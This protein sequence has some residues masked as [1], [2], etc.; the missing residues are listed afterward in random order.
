MSIANTIS[1]IQRLNRTIS[2]VKLAP[3]KYPG[4][5]NSADLPLVL[6]WP[7]RA[8][9]VPLTSRAE[10]VKMQR[11]Y[12]VRV[13][14]EAAGQDD[15]TAPTNRGVALLNNFLDT[16]FRNKILEAGYAEIVNI[17]DTCLISGGTSV[18]E[19]MMQYSG[20]SYKGFVCV[21]NVIE[22]MGER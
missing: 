1:C 10:V 6:V 17:E 5:I 8:T 21:L 4:S 11:Q 14:V 2:G 15:Y 18:T 3:T 19:Q 7:G 13:Y 12:E 22:V 20:V 9:T 16:Y